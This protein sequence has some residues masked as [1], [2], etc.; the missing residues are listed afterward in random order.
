MG[1]TKR[2]H[3]T[4]RESTP[5][6]RE[7]IPAVAPRVKNAKSA[8]NTTSIQAVRVRKKMRENITTILESPSFKA[9]INPKSG[10]TQD[11]N[12]DSAIAKANNIPVSAISRALE[13]RIP[14]FPFPFISI[15]ECTANAALLSRAQKIYNHRDG[16][17]TGFDENGLKKRRK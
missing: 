16:F 9:G 6:Q 13:L 8:F 4:K 14:L 2:P 7:R 10:A 12:Q 11:S 1:P 5:P 17:C 3:K 15:W